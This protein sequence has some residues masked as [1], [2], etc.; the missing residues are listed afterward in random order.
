MVLLLVDHI[1][2]NLWSIKTVLRGVELAPGLQVDSFKSSLIRVNVNLMFL[3]SAV[4]FLH[5]RI[6]QGFVVYGL[7]SNHLPVCLSA[8]NTP[9]ASNVFLEVPS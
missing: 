4:D 2:K 5:C 6:V 7:S 9:S 3:V 8:F 1:V